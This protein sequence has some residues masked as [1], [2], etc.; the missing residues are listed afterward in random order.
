MQA[1]TNV[2]KTDAFQ[3]HVSE[4]INDGARN[5]F[6]CLSGAPGGEM[7]TLPT[8]SFV[9]GAALTA[10]DYQVM[11]KNGTALVWSPRSNIALYGN[12]ATVTAA[13]RVGVQIALGTD[14]TL[15]GSMNVLRELACADSLN[16]TYLANYFS[17]EDLWLMV[18]RNAAGGV[19]LDAQIGTLGFGHLADI[20][21]F[22]GRKNKDHRAVLAATPHDVV[23]VERA[24]KPLYGDAAIVGG[25]AQGC[26][27]VDVCGGAKSVC[28]VSEVGK[29]YAALAEANAKTL[30][31]FFCDATPPGE[32]TCTPKRPQA[33]DGS[34]VYDGTIKADDSDGDGI[35]NSADNCATVFNPIR[36]VD[37]GAQADGDGDGIGD[38]CDPC[39]LDKAAMTCAKIDPFDV[40]ADGVPDSADNCPTVA[41]ADQA[42]GDSDFKGDVC[43]ACPALANANDNACPYTIM[44]LRTKPELQNTLVAVNNALVT[45]LVYSGAGSKRKLGGFFIQMKPG[46]AG[47][48]G[49][50][51]SGIYVFGTP[52]ADVKIGSRVNITVAQL[53]TYFGEFELEYATVVVPNP[54]AQEADP[55]PVV[56]SVADVA[57]GGPRA[58]ALEGVL[59]RVADVNVT[60]IAP[61]PGP[62]D[63]A[64]TNEYVLDD[65]LRVDDFTVEVA[66]PLPLVGTNFATV[67]GVL[68][69]RNGNSKIGA[70][71]DA[72]IVLGP[73]QLALFGPETTYTHIG[74]VDQP[75]L[76]A[77]TPLTVK[78]SGIVAVDTVVTLLSSDINMLT[79]PASVTVA[80]GSDS[81]VVPVSGIARGTVD[82]TATLGKISKK[83]KVRVLD[84]GTVD[85]VEVTALTPPTARVLGIGG[86]TTLTVTLSL[87]APLGGIDV[88]LAAGTWLVGSGGT[89]V[90]TVHVE[91]NALSATFTVTQAGG[92]AVLSDTVTATLGVSSAQAMLSV[93]VY[94]M[95]N[96]ADYTIP[97]TTGGDPNEFVELY[98]PYELPIPLDG[99]KVVFTRLTGSGNI[100]PYDF[101]VPLTGTLDPGHFIV[102]ANQAAITNFSA[103]PDW[104]PDKVKAVV[105]VDPVKS[106]DGWFVNGSPG[107]IGIFDTQAVQIVA[108]FGWGRP[109]QSTINSTIPGTFNFGENTPVTETMLVP[110]A[111]WTDTDPA[112]TKR[113]G[114][115]IRFPDGA[116]TGNFKTDIHQTKTVTP[117]FANVFTP[118]P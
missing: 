115:L 87:P 48:S 35:T 94:P 14:W 107:A 106:K 40:D 108:A 27:A 88:A 96:E 20:A 104:N 91:E 51:N 59:V 89:N 64:P 118:Y 72:D 41:N 105:L 113:N 61:A 103:Q 114:S 5:E 9:H 93:A 66:P 11:A 84:D 50:E 57:T 62:G 73:P 17:D 7:L 10:A 21:I 33:V 65:K 37:H 76:P 4:G 75:T 77:A 78:L 43:D 31:A 101:D 2:A 8:T 92:T 69:F 110:D 83:A 44:E 46:D 63:K 26:D 16:K 60:D 99:L 67:T 1:L 80:A 36:P 49:P 53:T 109:L 54:T 117:G 30:D 86:A 82:V 79:V 32:P 29:S 95:I 39:P 34:T 23:L 58:A 56:V 3:A 47:Y 18:T 42:D 25:L 68:A 38:A 112:K 55:D 45:A 12:T 97:H 85:I 71:G 90:G 24:G 100:S 13:A 15:S 19:G 74:T 116:S 28:A 102:I 111:H 70:R 22:D 81:V 98:N 52:P 6:L